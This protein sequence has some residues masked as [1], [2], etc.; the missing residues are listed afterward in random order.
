MI[1]MR[2]SDGICLLTSKWTNNDCKEDC[3]D[4]EIYKEYEAEEYKNM[5]ANKL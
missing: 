1:D 5:L 2:G 3:K 4:C